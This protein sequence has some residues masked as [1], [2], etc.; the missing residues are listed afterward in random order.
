MMPGG[1]GR[2]WPIAAQRM[3][4]FGHRAPHPEVTAYIQVS[5]SGDPRSFAWVVPVPLRLHSAGDDPCIPL[6]ITWLSTTPALAPL[7]LRRRV[8]RR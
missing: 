8:G 7:V 1:P 4:V 3:T 6:H 2:I 5:W